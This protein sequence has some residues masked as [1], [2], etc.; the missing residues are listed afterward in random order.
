MESNINV[1]D[2]YVSQ[3]NYYKT[4]IIVSKPTSNFV[5]AEVCVLADTGEVFVK[6]VRLITSLYVRI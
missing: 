4:F 2:M 5:D 1:G 3:K 6:Y